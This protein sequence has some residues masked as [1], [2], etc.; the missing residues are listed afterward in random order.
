MK[1]Q[2]KLKTNKKKRLTILITVIALI[3]IIVGSIVIKNVVVNQEAEGENYLAGGNA[4]SSLM[5]SYIRKGITIGGITGTLE[6][7]DTSDATAKA[8]D[9]LEGKTAYVNGVKITGTMKTGPGLGDITG[10]EKENTETQ[11]SLGNKVIVPAGFKVVNPQDNVEKGIIIEDVSAGNTNTKGSQFVWVPVGKIKTSQGEKEI[12][13][14]RY[15][16][17]DSG[18]ETL[19][20]SAENYADETQLKTSSTSSYYYQELLNTT[21]SENTKAKDIKEFVTKTLSIGGYYIGRYEAG[22]ALATSSARGS[23][24]SDTNPI[25]CKTG[26]YPYNYIKQLQAASL[27]QNMYS[28][29]N[30]TSDLINSYAWDTAIVFIQECSGDKNYSRQIGKNTESSLQKAGESILA[31]VDSGDEAK[32]VRCNIYD[33]SGNTYEWTTETNSNTSSPCVRRGGYYPNSNYCTSNRLSNNTSY[34]IS[35]IAC[36]PTLYL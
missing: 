2:G 3:G 15:T 21:S 25:V 35:N 31:N 13:L 11:D 16:F 4:S 24:T 28:G 30:F 29:T 6:S 23:S 26:V 5:A 12:T 20:Q 19:V 10:E 18:N 22:D 8:E 7:L 32:D 1:E 34:S 9:I 14:G 36:R 17:D 33:M 27:C